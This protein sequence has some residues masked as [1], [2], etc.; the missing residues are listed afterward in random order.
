MLGRSMDVGRCAGGLEGAVQSRP[1]M[2][3]DMDDR[4]RYVLNQPIEYGVEQLGNL[5]TSKC[6]SF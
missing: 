1:Q 5:G 6:T 3:E 2:R 4:L